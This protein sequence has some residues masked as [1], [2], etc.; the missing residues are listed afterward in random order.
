MAKKEVDQNIGL[1]FGQVL[2]KNVAQIAK[3]LWKRLICEK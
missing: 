3:W 2:Y 1:D